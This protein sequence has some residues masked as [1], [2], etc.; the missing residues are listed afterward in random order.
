M[1]RERPIR[2]PAAGYRSIWNVRERIPMSFPAATRHSVEIR[3][4]YVLRNLPLGPRMEEVHSQLD[5]ARSSHRMPQTAFESLLRMF[6]SL[7]RPTFAA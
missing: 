1:L 6:I 7:H 2:H 3:S 5:S 4:L